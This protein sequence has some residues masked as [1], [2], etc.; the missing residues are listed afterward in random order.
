MRP[1]VF[2]FVLCGAI[3]VFTAHATAA[4]VKAASSDGEATVYLLDNFSADFDLTYRA[5]LKPTAH[6][7]SWSSLSILLVGSQIPG[8]GAS[9]GV[10]HGQDLGDDFARLA[11]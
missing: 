10:N 8:P 2:A 6:N 9:V 7:K 4:D 3:G 5:V 1:R 11:S